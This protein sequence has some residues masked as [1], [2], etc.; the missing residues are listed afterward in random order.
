MMEIDFIAT[1]ITQL[2][3]NMGVS[4][5]DMSLSMGLADNYINYIENKKGLPSITVFFYICEY[6]K[7][8]PQEFFDEGNQNPE[9]L[10]ALIADLKQLNPTAL[11]HISGVV[12]EM[13]SKK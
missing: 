1:R 9:R 13:L 11:S 2:R 3:M 12:Q 7:V 5:R 10:N 6:L 4:A 8:T